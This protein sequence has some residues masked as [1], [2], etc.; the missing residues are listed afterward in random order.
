MSCSSGNCV[1][2]GCISEADTCEDVLLRRDT[3]F[4]WKQPGK[5][6]CDVLLE[7]MFGKGINITQQTKNDA[8]WYWFT[9]PLFAGLC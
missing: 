3:C 9:L 8:M 5:G 2:R 7:S 4:F 1:R 6:A